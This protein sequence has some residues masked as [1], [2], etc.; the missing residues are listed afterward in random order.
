MCYV[1]CSHYLHVELLSEESPA[2]LNRGGR[3]MWNFWSSTV[4][5][6]ASSGHGHQWA[7]KTTGN[8]A[9]GPKSW[10]LSNVKTFFKSPEAEPGGG[11]RSLDCV[12]WP[13][14]M[15]WRVPNKVGQT[16]GFPTCSF[17]CGKQP[18]YKHL[19]T[20]YWFSSFGAER[21]VLT[22]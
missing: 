5:L 21:P 19:S 8:T 11:S 4:P 2:A 15:S 3:T 22:H 18:Q 9:E 17:N 16:A 20:T 6:K 12:W 13:T 7:P 1:T 10:F 14:E